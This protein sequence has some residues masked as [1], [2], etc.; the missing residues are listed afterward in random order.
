MCCCKRGLCSP[1]QRPAESVAPA[2]GAWHDASD[3]R[4]ADGAP[5]LGH[6]AAASERP[7]HSAG[8]GA[9]AA[10]TAVSA[11]Q[12][13]HSHAA[14]ALVVDAN[15][16][17]STVTAAQ[18]AA[19]PKRKRTR[20]EAS[21]T[22]SLGEAGA[23]D[24][25][26]AGTASGGIDNVT[27]ATAV[28]GDAQPSTPAAASLANG[29]RP[30]AESQEEA[31]VGKKKEKKRKLSSAA[32]GGGEHSQSVQTKPG[33]DAN[34]GQTAHATQDARAVSVDAAARSNA[35]PTKKAKRAKKKV[36]QGKG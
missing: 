12:R 34:V 16:T 25:A 15:I 30:A 24:A 3:E 29:D 2:A 10:A 8:K 17:S 21:N 6:T 9:P 20:E 7:D 27:L 35:E 11:G 28:D 36:V 23:D 26:T 1:L 33:S 31:A 5:A 19:K 14:D 18:P 4:S 13:N 22:N 32:Q